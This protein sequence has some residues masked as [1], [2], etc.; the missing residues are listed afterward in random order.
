M[1]RAE[2]V[3][4]MIKASES[5]DKRQMKRD[6]KESIELDDNSGIPNV[7]TN[8][9]IALE[10]LSELQKELTKY[11][12]GHRDEIGLAEEMADVIIMLVYISEIC[13]VPFDRVYQALNVKLKRMEYRNAL[14]R[15]TDSRGIPGT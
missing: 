8:L 12:R 4:R 11:I 15:N 10:E 5:L 1:K 13:D 3:N 2:L 14:A 7:S 6:V 9:I